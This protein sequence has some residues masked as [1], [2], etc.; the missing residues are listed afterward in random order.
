MKDQ[1][2]TVQ[3]LL[4]R[5]ANKA[6]RQK[7]NR[8]RNMYGMLNEEM[9]KDSWRFIRKDAAYGVD[10]LSALEYEQN[11]EENVHKLVEN[12]N[13]NRYRSKLVRRR[14]IPKREGKYR[15]LGISAV[16]DKLLQAA[17]KQILEVIYEQ[18]FLSRQLGSIQT[19]QFVQAI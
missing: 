15:P 1:K 2:R 12:L 11:L 9:L 5:I 10:K 17:V 16:E 3:T 14:Y 8:F 7:G 18:D 19:D 6:E 13:R 4:Q